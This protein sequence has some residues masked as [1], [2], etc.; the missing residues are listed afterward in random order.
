MLLCLCRL[1][2]IIPLPCLLSDDMLE[3]QTTGFVLDQYVG[4]SFLPLLDISFDLEGT[5]DSEILNPD[6][7]M[8]TIN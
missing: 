3:E 1:I 7:N 4:Q 5:N 8:L 6:D 2:L